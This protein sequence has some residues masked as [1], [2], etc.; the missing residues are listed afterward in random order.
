MS[1]PQTAGDE[2]QGQHVF[3]QATALPKMHEPRTILSCREV[4]AWC[5]RVRDMKAPIVSEENWAGVSIGVFVGLLIY[6]LSGNFAHH[7]ETH[8]AVVAGVIF[9][10]ALAVVL[11]SLAW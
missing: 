2:A 9:T 6:L 8:G 7:A 3:T 11:G 1:A 4:T 5:K 10:G